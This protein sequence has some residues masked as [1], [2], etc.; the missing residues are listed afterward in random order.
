MQTEEFLEAVL[1]SKMK[2]YTN[3]RTS[4]TLVRRGCAK[5]DEE[6]KIIMEDREADH[7]AKRLLANRAA[8]NRRVP[9]YCYTVKAGAVA[10]TFPEQVTPLLSNVDAR[11]VLFSTL[12]R[13]FKVFLLTS[14]MERRLT[15]LKGRAQDGPANHNVRTPCNPPLSLVTLKLWIEE[16][17]ANLTDSSS[18][19]EG[20]R[21]PPLSISSPSVR[22]RRTPFA[23]KLL[24]FTQ[25]FPEFSLDLSKYTKA[26]QDALQP[27]PA[28]TT[29]AEDAPPV[30]TFAKVTSAPVD[31][32]TDP[33]YLLGPSEGAYLQ[34][35][36]DLRR[37]G[38]AVKDCATRKKQRNLKQQSVSMGYFDPVLAQCPRTTMSVS[39]EEHD[40]EDEDQSSHAPLPGA[41]SKVVW[42]TPPRTNK[43]MD[44]AFGEHT[45]TLNAFVNSFPM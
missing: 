38:Y 14:R 23:F 10:T 21:I 32:E 17:P 11:L 22:S 45:L 19:L 6:E 44:T 13:A 42:G 15:K 24:G 1:R 29:A 30:T 27:V 20:F 36:Y 33:T 7:L 28:T 8:M 34:V 3:K 26:E 43:S 41:P 12:R 40:S 4:N 37:G 9:D 35:K 18:S 25:G 31:I 39:M 16:A 5:S 2:E